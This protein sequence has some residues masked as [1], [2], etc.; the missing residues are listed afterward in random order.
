MRSASEAPAP[1]F[2]WAQNSVPNSVLRRLEEL[3]QGR[4]WVKGA[5]NYDEDL[6]FSTYYL[7]ASSSAV[8][9]PLYPGYSWVVASYQ[10]FNETY[11]LLEQECRQS[12]VAIVE[13]ALREPGWLPQILREIRRR[14]DALAEIF[15]TETSAV[16][17]RRLS[18]ARLLA[19]YRRHDA[20]NRALYQCARLPEALDRG[21][22]YFTGY[23][24]EHLR[25]MGM[26]APESVEAFAVLSQP[27]V[28]SVLA[29]EILDFDQFVQYARSEP[30]AMPPAAHGPGRARMLLERELF[31]RLE[32]HLEKWKFLPYHGYARRELATL[33]QYV[34]RLLGQALNPA[35]LAEGRGMVMRCQQAKAQQKRL[36]RRLNLD[37]PH[38]AL[39]GVYPE[40]GA[41]KLYR[42]Y[43]QLR[44]FYFLDLLL[45]EIGR[46]LDLCE[47]TVRCMV[48]E[49]IVASLGFGRLASPEVGE[50]RKGCVFAILDGREHILTGDS[51][52]RARR[53]FR[54][55]PNRG[56]PQEVLR[57]VVA[58]RGKAAGP[59][60]VIIR[61]DDCR[62]GFPKGSIL[63]SESTDPDLLPF[64]RVAG[65]VLTEQGGVTSH[66]AIICRELGIPTITGVERL[67]ESV[68]DGDWVQMDAEH[69]LV[70]LSPASGKGRHAA[71]AESVLPPPPFLIGAK[72][73]N[74]G[75]VRSLGFQVPEY[76]VVGWE[77]VH[78]VARQ[79]RARFSRE[80]VQRVLSELKLPQREKLAVRSSAVAEDREEGSGAGQYRSLL[81]I[82]QD[83][84]APAFREFIAS[85]GNC[86]HGRP[87][88]RGSVI[89]QRMVQADCGGVCLTRD[90]RT[91]NGDAVIIELTAGTNTGVTGGTARPDRLVVDRLTGDILDE[92]RRSASLCLPALDVSGLV[93][94]FLTLE[95]RFGKPLDI[96]WAVVGQ[97]LYIL[98]ARPIVA[99][100]TE[101]KG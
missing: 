39:F 44:N 29:Q 11:Y 68:H 90:E 36:L 85:N 4:V 50:R 38:A 91:G 87:A 49:E 9:A 10:N 45:A 89:V 13:R 26:D 93:Q 54:P 47:W 15:P 52:E 22:S 79:P 81:N 76:V 82:G 62:D 57:G 61:A 3:A 25:L 33:D 88:Y 94:Q 6:H 80:L 96:E 2:K 53:L 55:E 18:N 56:G 37:T 14:S 20:C 72:A 67:L 70:H 34:S 16:T 46:R 5:V 92:K 21:V 59:C 97:Q 84:L 48:P 71:P 101:A 73:F 75:R 12:A 31:R 23:L 7:R 42:R 51:A 43:A 66:A 28:P 98:Q 95:S 19:L 41:C 30:G 99:P 60:K 100:N 35:P 74:L 83:R 78:R 27:I 58:C 24:M 40:I 32:A 63:V 8:T 65:G 69:G 17:L 1:H 86:C 64:L 77:D